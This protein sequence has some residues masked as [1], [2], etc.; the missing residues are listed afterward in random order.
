MKK[1]LIL[2]VIFYSLINAQ[3]QVKSTYLQNPEKAIGFVDSCATFWLK[4]YDSVNG[5]FYTN[6]GKTGNL[7]TSSGTQKNMQT[8]SRDAYG[9]VRAFMLTGNDNYLTKA[10]QAL[11]FM[12]AHAWDNTNGGWYWELDKYGNPTSG[13]TNK[14]AFHQHYGLLGPMAY[15]EATSD[16]LDWNWIQKSYINNETKMWDNSL[17]YFGYYDYCSSNWSSKNGK[18]FNATVDAITTHLLYLYLITK[19]RQYLDKTL[20]IIDNM[21]N[22]FVASMDNQAIGFAEVYN[23]SWNINTSETMTIMGHVL[24]TAWCFARVYQINP[25]TTYI[26]S[27]RKLITNVLQKG[28]DNQFGGPYKD[29]NRV[30]GQMLMWSNPDTAKAWWQME[31]AV[32][33]GLQMYQITQAD[34]YLKMADETLD[35]FMKNFVDHQYG[36]VYENRTRYGGQTWGENKGNPNKAGYHSIELGYY[37]YL[38]GKFFVTKE[39]ITLY[40]NFQPGTERDI[41]LNPIELPFDTYKITEVIYNNQQY[42]QFSA[43]THLLHLAANIGGK[44]KVTFELNPTSVIANEEKNIPQ[45][46]KLAQN[47]PNPFNSSTK[48][49]YSI[50]SSNKVTIKVYDI[51]GTKITTLVDGF[52]NAGTYEVNFDGS[53]LSSGTY[54]YRIE[55]GTFCETKKLLLLK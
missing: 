45:Q 5:G 15:Y 18:S 50:P 37:T 30:T 24:K 34:A 49:N 12:Y 17:Q 42:N 4:A 31:Q 32:V 11:T 16:T 40:Y 47:F 2:F 7:L 20:K 14:D 8:Q 6:I 51:L 39:P 46:F 27:A 53:K 28:Y 9:F 26:A 23:S 19:D 10:K 52:K 3:Y 36:E 25:D 33:A 43:T 48:I 44:F 38:Y 22:R 13:N 29:Y 41:S 21:Q 35:F 1:L 54:F 55:A